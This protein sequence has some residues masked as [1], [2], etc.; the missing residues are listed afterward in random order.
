MPRAS[1]Y[2][3]PRVAA[4]RIDVHPAGENSTNTTRTLP[5][6]VH[7]RPTYAPAGGPICG[8]LSRGTNRFG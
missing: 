6:S 5:T 2:S 1:G 3:Y 8:N 7:V 4:I